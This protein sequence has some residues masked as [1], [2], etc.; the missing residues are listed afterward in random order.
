MD[1]S[2][3]VDSSFQAKPYR[4]A[5]KVASY[6]A[7]IACAL[8]AGLL[9]VMLV[10]ILADGPEMAKRA[11]RERSQ[12]IEQENLAFCEKFGIYRNTTWFADCAKGLTEVRSRHA[13]RISEPGVF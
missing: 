3:S 7:S 2:V 12:Q 8:A 5:A 6:V 11:E 1:P 13:E 9:C 4:T 10:V